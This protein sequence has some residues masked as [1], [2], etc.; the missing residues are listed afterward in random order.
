[1]RT[2]TQTYHA[3][4]EHGVFR[5]SPPLHMNIPEGQ[6]VRIVVEPIESP[7]DILE[8]ATRVYDGFSAKDIEE[9]EEIILG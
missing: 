7:E 6:A 9:I 2:T 5:V 4:F 8:L 1:M 3:V